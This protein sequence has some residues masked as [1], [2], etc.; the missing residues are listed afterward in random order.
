M[1]TNVR[2]FLRQT[3]CRGVLVALTFSSA[4]S[5]AERP[6]VAS[7]S[8]VRAFQVD[9]FRAEVR[10][11]YT[12]AH[13]LP[14]RESLCVAIDGN[15][16]INWNTPILGTH[17]VAVRVTDAG[18]A[19]DEQEFFATG[20]VDIEEAMAYVDGLGVPVHASV[21]GLCPASHLG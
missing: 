4:G 13:G 18:G 11:T 5:S 20:T 8:N 12:A 21:D 10:K 2:V 7:P 6:P 3:V 15:G 19:W 9:P 16:V 17:D 14:H 1:T